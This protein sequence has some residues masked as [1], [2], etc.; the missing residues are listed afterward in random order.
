MRPLLFLLLFSFFSM[1]TQAQSAASFFP[2]QLGYTWHYTIATLDT[3]QT[4]VPNSERTQ[5][6]SLAG[7]MLYQ[8]KQAKVILTLERIAQAIPHSLVWKA[9]MAFNTLVL[10]CP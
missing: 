8:G 9:Q 2:T 3:L 5:I 7:E 1:R 4:I 6:D 10:T